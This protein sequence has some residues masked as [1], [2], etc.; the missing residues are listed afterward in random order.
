MDQEKLIEAP[1]GEEVVYDDIIQDRGRYRSIGHYSQWGPN[2]PSHTMEYPLVPKTRENKNS[3]RYFIFQPR[4]K[5]NTTIKGIA[6]RR[7]KSM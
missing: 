7:E 5:M 2:R 4:N 3:F 6:Y 1:G